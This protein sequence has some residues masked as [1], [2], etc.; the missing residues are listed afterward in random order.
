ME[1]IPD[2][3]GSG[4]EFAHPGAILWSRQVDIAEMTV[5]H[6]IPSPQLY[7]GWYDPEGTIIHNDHDNYFYYG[8]TDIETPFAQDSGVTYWLAISSSLIDMSGEAW[9][10]KNSADHYQGNAVWTTNNVVWQQLADPDEIVDSFNLAF[11]VDDGLGC[12]CFPGDANNDGTINVGDAVYIINYVFKGGSPPAP[13]PLCSG[14]AN[15]DCQLNVGDAVYL[16]SYVFK[17]GPPPCD[18][19]GWK[20]TCGQPMRE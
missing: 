17:G 15:C 20:S 11:V 9:G 1:D 19:Q 2:P 12:D 7:E 3:D 4:P 14:D 6:I 10:W 5:R 13:Y 16:I 8:Y 18:C